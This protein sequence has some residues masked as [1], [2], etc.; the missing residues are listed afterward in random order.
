MPTRRPAAPRVQLTLRTA[1]RCALFAALAALGCGLAGSAPARAAGIPESAYSDLHWRLVGPFRAGWATAVAGVPGNPARFYLGAADGGV[2]RTDNAGV[3]WRSLF[4]H[5]GSA[6]VGALAVAPSDPTVIWVGTGQI[7]QRWDIAAGDGVYR[8]TDGGETWSHVGLTETRHIGDLWVDPRDA[9]VAL[10][11]ALGHVFGPNPERGI[12]RTEDGGATWTKVLYRDPDTGACDIAGDPALPDLLYASLWQVRRHA[13]LDY[14]Q[15]PVGPGSGIWKSSDAGRSWQPVGGQ[16]LPA[17][18]LGRIELAVAPGRGAQTVWASIDTP[19][20]A[21]GGLYRSDDGGATWTLEN[22][23]PDLASSYTAGLTVDPH[24]ADVL[25]AMGRGM[26]RSGDGGKTFTVVK[27]SPGGDDY[28]DLW[29][30][31]LDSQRRILGSDQ[32]AAVSLDGGASWS[33]WYNQPTGQF[34]RV[35]VD[36]RF[37]YRIYSGQQDSGTVGIASRGDY[38]QITFRDWNPVGGDERDGDV[39]DPTDPDIVYGAGLGGRLSKWN[40][41]TGQVQNVAPWPVSMYATRPGTSRYRYTWITP[42]A[43]APRPPHAI[44]VGAQVVFRSLDGGQS[45][46][47]ISPDLTGAVAGEKE[48]DGDVPIERTVACGWGTIFTIAPSAAADGLIWVGTDT[49]RVQVT[50]DGGTTW[51]DVSPPGV[52]DWTKIDTVDPSPTDARTAYV[53]GDRHRLDDRRPL[54]W[55]THDGGATWTE[56]GHGLPAGEW[57]G[58]LRQDPIHA[59]LLYAGTD[60]GVYVSFDDGDSWQ[61]LDAGLPTTGIND[62]V[63]HAGD[64]VAVTEG[65]G[66]WVLDAI[67][68][69]RHLKAGD[70]AGAFLSPPPTAFRLRANQ[71]KD[72]PLPPEEPRGENPP[73]GAVIDYVLPAGFQGPVTLDVADPAGRIV[74]HETSAA[75]P[76]ARSAEEPYFTDLYLGAAQPLPATPGHHRVVWNLRQPAPPV[77]E[78]EYSI[79]AVPG[80]PTPLNPEGAFVLPGRYEVR[81][82]AGG[83]TLTQPL[84]VVM[85]PRVLTSTADLMALADF[86]RKVDAALARVVPVAQSAAAVGD[87]LDSVA[88]DPRA[89][90]LKDE[91]ATVRKQLEDARG[92]RG[93]SARTIAGELAALATDLG[94]ADAAPTGPQQQVLDQA[95]ERFTP[96]ETRWKKF[97]GGPLAALER[98]LARAGLKLEPAAPG[99]GAAGGAGRRHSSRAELP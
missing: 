81:L 57:L 2:W 66:I 45:W 55:R 10:V 72:T 33:S 44:F 95:L 12:F 52:A 85:D 16:G 21:G 4:D 17:G 73:V 70:L 22:G 59:G 90:D 23:E 46:E 80:K 68:M 83:K 64:L 71:N 58:V 41:R 84:A 20:G 25:Y 92:P 7:Q 99:T 50:W 11:A 69:L 65:R 30:D 15:P 6:S 62:M 3:T 5:Q 18:P 82:T 98:K 60:R 27:G 43:I 74:H 8:S 88:A 48:C 76:P 77:F 86:Q 54:A 14:F 89:T 97:Q 19:P 42:L 93:D 96:I 37:P 9:R 1:I 34:Y 29:I 53:A 38:G 94:S 47:T 51:K 36:D 87:G 40:A 35:A 63:V 61:G 13:W 56:I 49:G 67:E 26:R 75:A 31:P 39:P 24:D 91:I 32:G 79:A 28:H 78:G